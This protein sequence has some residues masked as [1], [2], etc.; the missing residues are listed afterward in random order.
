MHQQQPEQA[1][2]AQQYLLLST[3]AIVKQMKVCLVLDSGHSLKSLHCALYMDNCTQ[4]AH[5]RHSNRSAAWRYASCLQMNTL[6][7][8]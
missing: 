1:Q 2:Q 8:I 7:V 4:T 5:R 6:S 3:E